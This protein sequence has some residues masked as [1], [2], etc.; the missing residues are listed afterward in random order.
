MKLAP[1]RQA[2]IDKYSA[3]INDHL[4]N[5][6]KSG[7]VQEIQ[8]VP[9]HTNE[10]LSLAL[11]EYDQEIYSMLREMIEDWEQRTG[12]DGEKTL[13][14]LGLRRVADEFNGAPNV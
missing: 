3:I 14:S 1:Q 9:Q 12:E 4:R 13:Y 10:Y 6:V 11:D 7:M 8:Q 5:V 2:I